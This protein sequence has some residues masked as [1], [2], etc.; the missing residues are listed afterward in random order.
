M[1]KVA[2][3]KPID[4]KRIG[5]I[6]VRSTNWVGD[7]VMTIPALEAIKENFPA[8]NLTVLARPWVIP[9]L[10]NNPGV[11]QVLPFKKG[12]GF[13]SNIV[14]V[15]RAASLIR[16]LGF[17]LALLFQN[18]FE[19]A[20]LTCL[21]GI[22][23]RVGYNTDGR[24]LLLSHA[25]IRD[26]EILRQH[27]VE[28]YLGILRAF[29][30]EA[31]SKDPSLHVAEKEMWAARTILSSHGIEEG[32]FVVGLSPGAIYGPAKRWPIER[33]AL[34]GDWAA[35]R[36]G[37]RVLVMGSQ[38]EKSL[39][40]NLG[41]LMKHHPVNLCGSTTLG[42]AMALIKRC[43]L[44]VS[45]DSGL[46]HVAAALRVP[47]VAVF[48]STDPV[49]TGPRGDT[50][51]IVRRPI[52]CSPCLRPECPTDYRCMLSIGAEEVWKEMER[53][54]EQVGHGFAG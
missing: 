8:S 47:T 14:E 35:E 18:A 44:F 3:Q 17:D 32:D 10:E 38:T 25:V 53:L 43:R 30:W 11:D 36:W 9:L 4:K 28:Y 15:I 23:F 6:L 50:A 12:K 34:I 26:R 19:A 29:G 52:A 21:G 31:P 7:A 37:A 54:A 20:L 27:Q 13:L 2:G 45:N 22:R 40:E 24:R 42:E 46:M 16:G 51:R 1:I 49:A 39:G 41:R 48:G 5:R 33:F